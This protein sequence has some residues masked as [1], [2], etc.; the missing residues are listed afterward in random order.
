MILTEGLK[1]SKQSST[2]HSREPP[3]AQ[4]GLFYTCTKHKFLTQIT[5]MEQ[6]Q[7]LKLM[8]F[9]SLV[10]VDRNCD[11]YEDCHWVQNARE[12]FGVSINDIAVSCQNITVELERVSYYRYGEKC[13]SQ[14]Q[15]AVCRG[16]HCVYVVECL[17]H[18]FSFSINI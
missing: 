6:K 1:Q 8:L 2:R 16:V 17:S 15:C 11:W 12:H 10:D 7:G 14:D 13:K 3:F 18:K 5:M 4:G 9:F